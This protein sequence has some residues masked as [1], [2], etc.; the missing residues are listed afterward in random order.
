ME[1]YFNI[2]NRIG[3]FTRYFASFCLFVVF[4]LFLANV[5]TR[6]N[7][8]SW[9]PTW[10]DETIQ[11][12]LVWLIFLS[13]AE[14]V[15]TREHFMVDILVDKLKGTNI[16]YYLRFISVLILLVTYLTILY[17]SI[18]LCLKADIRS[19]FTLPSFVK[20]SWFYLC[21]P[22]STFL[23]CIYTIRDIIIAFFDIINKG[24]TSN[25]LKKYFIKM[26]QNEDQDAITK[27]KEK[28][29]LEK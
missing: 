9:N 15:R 11:F 21:I 23:M 1:I 25:N 7:F 8:I 19:T 5:I 29:N 4:I 26:T 3:N 20:M 14:L 27:A 16:G 24:Q 12:F 28:L 6:F 22:I 13:A 18:K 2:E 10:I 17:F